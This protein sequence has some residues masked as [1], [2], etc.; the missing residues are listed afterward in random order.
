VVGWFRTHTRPG[1]FLD[2]HDFGLFN[3][4]FAHPAS[5]ALLIRPED[6]EAAFFF[7]EDGDIRRAAPYQTFPFIPEALGTRRESRSPGSDVELIAVPASS[8]RTPPVV[9]WRRRALYAAPIAASVLAGFLWQPDIERRRTA[10]PV[11]SRRYVIPERAVFPPPERLEVVSSATV[12]SSATVVEQPAP[13]VAA[14]TA[15]KA[16]RVRKVVN[17]RSV[18]KFAD[19]KPRPRRVVVPEPV[20]DIAAPPVASVAKLESPPV[21]YRA[22]EVPKPHHS[23]QEQKPSKVRRVF[24]S[25]PL[26]GFL[27]KKK[28]HAQEAAMA[29]HEIKGVSTA[30]TSP[31]APLASPA[32][33][34]RSQETGSGSRTVGPADR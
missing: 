5:V 34:L 25:I 10:E 27:K 24:G 19:A 29:P 32:R 21:I 7:W 20:L 1:L 23:V 12:E 16:P 22:D 13:V 11:E 2:Q 4:Y 17:K 18:R 8:L 9:D 28:P 26:L 15:P 3:D 33:R 31:E 14:S 6:R 30:L